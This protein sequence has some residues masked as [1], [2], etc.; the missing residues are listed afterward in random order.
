MFRQ[1]LEKYSRNKIVKRHLPQR[2][3]GQPIYVSPDSAL[4]YWKAD[5][6]RP[7]QDGSAELEA[8]Q[9]R[10]ER[11]GDLGLARECRQG[12]RLS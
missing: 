8:W 12:V 7:F 11:H 10:L 5:L 6:E 2:F 3:G 4:S 9:I 1:L